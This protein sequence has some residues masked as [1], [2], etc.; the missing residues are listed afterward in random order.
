MAK[1]KKKKYKIPG[2]VLISDL[3]RLAEEDLQHNRPDQ[4]IKRLLPAEA[5]LQR[6][7]SPNGGK[8]PSLPP[9]LAAAQPATAQ[10][11]A[12]AFFTRAFEAKDLHHK[13]ADLNEA[14]K[15]APAERRYPLALG[16]CL[17][18]A[19][20][21]EAAREQL[22][23]ARALAPGDHLVARA[24]L[25][26]LLAT[27]QTREA[28]AA[29]RQLLAASDEP[30][31]KR[32][33]A[34]RSLIVGHTA[35][36]VAEHLAV[37]GALAPLAGQLIRGL[38]HLAAGEL[39]RAQEQLAALPPLDHH[40]S[41][42]EAA[43]LATQLFYCG[44]AHFQ[45]Q[46]LVEASA[47]WRQAQ[48]LAGAHAL[49][50]PWRDRLAIYYHQLADSALQANDLGLAA[51]C[52][53]HA[54]ELA[55]DDKV[56]AANLAAA[57]RVEAN[58]AWR[59]GQTERAI[60]LWQEM[61]SANARDER[62]LRN[63]AIALEKAARPDEAITHWRRL[64]EGWRQQLKT[65]SSEPGFKDRLMRLEPHLVKLMTEAGQS[66]HEVLNEL[67]SAL[68]IDPANHEL[69]R[70]YA[71]LYLEIGRPQQALKH[72]EM[73]E[74]AQG[75]SADL[76]AQKGL[77]LELMRKQAAARQ[78]FERALELNPSHPT[79]RLSYLI[80]LGTEATEASER[81]QPKRARE[82]CQRQ[83]EIDPTYAPAL[84]HLAGLY[85]QLGQKEEAK[86][87]IARLSASEPNSPQKRAQAGGAYLRLK[88]K[89]EAA[90]EFKRA[91]EL[92]PSAPCLMNIGLHY[93]ECRDRQQAFQYFERAA[94]VASPE[95]LLDLA[96][97]LHQSG[98]DREAEK[99]VDRALASDPQHPV[100]HLAKAVMLL[101]RREM[102]S[103]RRELD[104]AERLATERAG[105]EYIVEAARNMRRDLEAL[106]LPSEIEELL[107]AMAGASG[108][109]P[110][111]RELR[112]LLSRLGG[113]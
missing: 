72:L 75:E 81:G 113:K 94:K 4:A 86:Q 70:R 35:S 37:E 49:A 105:Y 112:R 14:V 66:P 95:V 42:A 21:I 64:A 79:A 69:R 83:L 46:R 12:R 41:R 84:S 53:R 82:I 101:N 6:Q 11:L 23:Q 8:G 52:W 73:I 27:G 107:A 99:Y 111:P 24:D 62:L 20:R 55:P 80:L 39:E 45:A 104:E 63:L 43:L 88:F 2:V 48:Q 85:Y 65:R 57:R 17:L 108:L 68:K 106:A 91:I 50:L 93:L 22:R 110:M 36:A 96:H 98:D 10:L 15:R 38:S 76:L 89:K 29:L 16:T 5:Q 44:V 71:N 56:A 3:V 26:E 97:T 92:D 100:A 67:E 103:G 1:K 78:C 54:R 58:Q 32:L 19:G 102:K 30:G 60:A 31:L 47:D 87:T 74:R 18:M 34:I 25:L 90:A 9:H 61:L 13:L 40:P 109:P 33:A 51:E 28:G 59:A 7:S 77:A